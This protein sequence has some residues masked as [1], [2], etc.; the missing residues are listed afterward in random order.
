MKN[1]NREF[2]KD[3]GYFVSKKI[4]EKSEI[5]EAVKEGKKILNNFKKRKKEI[6]GN[7]PG[8]WKDEEDKNKSL[9]MPQSSAAL[10]SVFENDFQRKVLEN[11]TVINW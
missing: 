3:N 10:I 9:L 5:E 7:W 1:R 8:N 6:E 11:R 4:F 2:F